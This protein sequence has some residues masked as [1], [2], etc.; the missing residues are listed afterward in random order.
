MKILCI[1]TAT[2]ACSAALYIKGEC[3][4][5]YEVAP[6]RHGELIL[7]MVDRLL[8]DAQLTLTSL[9]AIAYGQGPGSFIGVRIAASVTQG[10][11]YAADLPV[12]AVSTL[13]ALAQGAQADFVLTAIDAR[14]NEV[15]WGEYH[16]NESGL[17]ELK[18]KETVSAPERVPIPEKLQVSWGGAGTGWNRYR[19]SLQRRISTDIVLQ[20]DL[21]P[22]ASSVG[23]LAAWMMQT[24]EVAVKAREA[25][26]TYLRDQVAYK[27]T[28]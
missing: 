15:Y 9:D 8:A 25:I 19:E 5:L 13:A 7:P 17:V 28:E 11:A 20:G 23:R 21:L 2:E 27:P 18:G 26:P 4:E 24:R 16:R 22:R 1:E 3:Q 14:M 6:Q 10:I 12:I